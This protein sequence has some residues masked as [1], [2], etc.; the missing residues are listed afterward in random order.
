MFCRYKQP[1][2]KS[3]LKGKTFRITNTITKRKTLEDAH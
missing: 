3:I 1:D 2:A